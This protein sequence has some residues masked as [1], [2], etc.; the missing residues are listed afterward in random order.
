M[1]DF[2]GFAVTYGIFAMT[3]FRYIRGLTLCSLHVPMNEQITDIHPSESGN[4]VKFKF[5]SP[6]QKHIYTAN[7]TMTYVADGHEGTVAAPF[8]PTWTVTD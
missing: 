1:G 6:A 5:Y 8:T 3:S 4:T 7:E 2:N